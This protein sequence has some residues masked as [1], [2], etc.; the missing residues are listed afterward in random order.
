MGTPSGFRVFRAFR[1]IPTA[2]F[3]PGNSQKVVNSSYTL[4]WGN[5]RSKITLLIPERKTS[6]GGEVF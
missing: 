4:K 2:G 5:D 6:P 3:Y 1:D